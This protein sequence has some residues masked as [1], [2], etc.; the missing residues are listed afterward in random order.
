VRVYVL[1][2]TLGLEPPKSIAEPLLH[3]TDEDGERKTDKRPNRSAEPSSHNEPYDNV[4]ER[5]Q[6]HP[7]KDDEPMASKSMASPDALSA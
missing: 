6:H 4:D 2:S 3:G 5:N 7:A 1:S